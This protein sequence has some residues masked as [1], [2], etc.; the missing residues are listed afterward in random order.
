MGIVIQIKQQQFVSN[1]VH[2]TVFNPFKY[3][4]D[5]NNI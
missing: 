4:F 3:V 1:I 5:Q 2:F